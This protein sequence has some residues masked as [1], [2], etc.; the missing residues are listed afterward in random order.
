MVFVCNSRFRLIL[1]AG[2]ILL[3]CHINPLR[4]WHG[5]QYDALALVSLKINLYIWQVLYV[6]NT[7]HDKADDINLYVLLQNFDLGKN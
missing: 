7:F 4:H 6:K 3:I 5:P 1:G 2:H